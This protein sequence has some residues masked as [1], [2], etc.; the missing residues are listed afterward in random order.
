MLVLMKLLVFEV[1]FMN[2]WNVCSEFL[3]CDFVVVVWKIVV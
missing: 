3:Y 2:W 1:V